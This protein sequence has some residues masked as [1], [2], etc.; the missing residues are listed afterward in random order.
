MRDLDLKTAL[1]LNLGDR[2]S[3]TVKGSKG[4]RVFELE[5]IDGHWTITTISS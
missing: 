2:D 4:Q 5:V 3:A 1:R